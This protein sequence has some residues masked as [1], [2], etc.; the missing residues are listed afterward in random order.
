MDLLTKKLTKRN[1][2][3]DCWYT[4]YE[5]LV[6]HVRIFTIT[7]LHST[8]RPQVGDQLEVSRF[9]DSKQIPNRNAVTL[10]L[11]KQ[12]SWDFAHFRGKANN[13]KG[14][15]RIS[16]FSTV[17]SCIRSSNLR[18]LDCN[19]VSWFKTLAVCRPIGHTDWQPLAPTTGMSNRH[20]SILLSTLLSSPYLNVGRV[21]FKVPIGPIVKYWQ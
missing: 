13:L 4:N 11:L 16:R 14:P 10:K 9:L 8:K 20:S 7:G 12:F 18:V 1:V 21:D 5:T 17:W 6:S 2:L 3:N 19:Q 15:F